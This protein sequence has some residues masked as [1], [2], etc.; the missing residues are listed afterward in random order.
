MYY[1][2]T[3]K[4]IFMK[5]IFAV[6]IVCALVKVTFAQESPNNFDVRLFRSINNSQS[7]FKNSLFGITNFSVT[8]L[9]IAIPISFMGYGLYNHDDVLFDNGILLSTAG[10]FSFGTKTLMKSLIKR[11]RPYD[12]LSNVHVLEYEYSD[13]YSF[14][15]GHATAAFSLATMISLQYSKPEVYIP[16]FLWAGLVGYGRIYSGV[17]YPTDVLTGALIG[18]GWSLLVFTYREEIISVTNKILGREKQGTA[19]VFPTQQGMIM[20]ISIKF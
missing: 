14:P 5:K 3:Q 20:N 9:S 2:E 6:F 15:S 12:E 7:S 18:T 13:P 8:P 10:V 16:A 1:C 11:K 4:I 17:H 19:I